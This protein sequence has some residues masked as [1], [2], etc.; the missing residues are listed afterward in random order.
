MDAFSIYNQI[1][2]DLTNQDKITFIIEEGLYCYKV[3]PFSLKNA[4]ATYQLLVNKIFA[5]NIGRIM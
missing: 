3:M 1:M 2:M 4:D 5:K